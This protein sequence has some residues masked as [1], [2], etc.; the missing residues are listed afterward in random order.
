MPD[1]RPFDVSG[2][3]LKEIAQQLLQMKTQARSVE[4]ISD[5]LFPLTATDAASD[6]LEEITGFAR[7]ISMVSTQLYQQI[8]KEAMQS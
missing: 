6:Q 2:T 7:R 8:A 4:N 1:D 5:A 3:T